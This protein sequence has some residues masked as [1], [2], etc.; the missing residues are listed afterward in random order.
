MDRNEDEKNAMK[1]ME[2]TAPRWFPPQ[3]KTLMIVIVPFLLILLAVRLILAT[4]SFL[5]SLEYERAIFPEDPYGFS[6]EDRIYWSMVDIEYLIDNSLTIDY[7]D[8]YTL[9]TGEP[10]HNERELRHMEDVKN[11]SEGFWMTGRVLLIIFII[12]SALLWNL[13][14]PSEFG[15]VLRGG[16]RATF[17]LMLAVLLAVILG[18]GDFF[19]GFHRIFFEGDTWLFKYSDTFIRLYPELFWQDLFILLAMLTALSAGILEFSGWKL[20]NLTS[21][22]EFSSDD[23]GNM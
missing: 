12:M 3:L 22:Y 7:F 16:A 6:T 23:I 9:A 17:L 20:R 15:R 2:K 1:D 8:N 10:M 19:V 4:A 13:E 11:L 18:F 14:S 21:C 5:V